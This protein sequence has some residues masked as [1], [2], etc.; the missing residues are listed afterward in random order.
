[1]GKAPGKKNV[2]EI[3]EGKRGEAGYLGYLLRQAANA[4]SNRA[5]RA[6]SDLGVTPPQFATLTMLAAYPGL[7]GADIARIAMLTP[8]TV[9]V[10]IAN[11]EKH[12]AIVRHPHPVH[13]RIQ[14]ADL[15]D[16]GR[17]LLAAARERMQTLEAELV[18]GMSEEQER[19]VR[20]WLVGVARAASGSAK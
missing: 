8:Q 16:T 20:N 12:G 13:G 5:E 9:S 14:T 18:D 2:P 7:S 15:T 3:G 17:G 10:I 1:M 11:L 4:Y 19:A 6:L